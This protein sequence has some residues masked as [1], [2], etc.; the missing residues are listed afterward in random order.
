MNNSE[1]L[2]ANSFQP[3]ENARSCRL[4]WLKAVIC[5]LFASEVF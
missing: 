4:L 5:S 3:E 2:A 1:Q